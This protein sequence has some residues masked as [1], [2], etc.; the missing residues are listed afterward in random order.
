M[1][2]T[3]A[4]ITIPKQGIGVEVDDE[5]IAVEPACPLAHGIWRPLVDAI[6]R[7]VEER[8]PEEVEHQSEAG[9]NRTRCEGCAYRAASTMA[10]QALG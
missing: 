7:P 10:S 5:Q 3:L 4:E 8:G 1:A 2:E 6:G 9:G